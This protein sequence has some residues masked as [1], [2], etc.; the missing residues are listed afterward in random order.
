MFQSITP[1]DK[2]N[3]YLD[4]IEIIYIEIRPSD[5]IWNNTWN[6]Q[7]HI[8]MCKKQQQA[9]LPVWNKA[10]GIEYISLLNLNRQA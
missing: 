5:S 4:K 10:P 2:E 1:S 6:Y 8:A 9:A 7:Q 3:E